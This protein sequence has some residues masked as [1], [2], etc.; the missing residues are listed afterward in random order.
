MRVRTYIYDSTTAADHVDAVLAALEDREEAVD[1][2]DVGVA[3][4]P[5]DARREAMLTLRESLRVGENP[6]GIYDAE[7]RPDFGT[8][9][10]ITETEVGRRSVHVGDEA[11]D[12]L[13]E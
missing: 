2:L 11:L 13:E 3:D 9:V 8:G 4:D 12:A 7:G 10:L 1:P 5:G 6:D